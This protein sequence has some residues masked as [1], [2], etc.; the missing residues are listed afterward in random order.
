M[1]L[2]FQIAQGS[3]HRIKTLPLAHHSI[4]TNESQEVLIT[5]LSSR[6][7]QYKEWPDDEMSKALKAVMIEG[8]SVQKAAEMYSVPKSTL[9]DK[10]SGRTHDG[11]SH[12]SRYLSDDEE[13]EL[14]IASY[15]IGC[16][17]I[18]YPKTVKEILARVQRMLSV[19]GAQCSVEY[20]RWEAFRRRH[21]N[22][23]LRS[24]SS[25]QNPAR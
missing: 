8:M 24:P 17:S 11:T 25:F 18:G 10:V 1:N 20:G 2:Y 22:L 16:A 9:G 21:P 15:N 14:A 4:C 5:M 19:R 3:S 13:E 23:S 12:S 6:P 7:K